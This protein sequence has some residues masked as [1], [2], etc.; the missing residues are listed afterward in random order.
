MER[1]LQ[2]IA[3]LAPG[4]QFDAFMTSIS[5]LLYIL[6]W[7][8]L[9][10]GLLLGLK[11][12]RMRPVHPGSTTDVTL[13][14]LIGAIM[15]ALTG[16]LWVA[17]NPIKIV[18]PYIHLRLFSFFTAVVGILFGRGA[19][20]ICGWVATMVWAPLAGAFVLPH[21]PLFD[22]IFVGLTGWIPAV[23]I[24]GNK[25]TAEVLRDIQ[26]NARLWY[27]K[28]AAACLFAGLFMSF[29][30]AVSLE[31][32]TTLTFWMSFW[33]IGIVSDTAPLVLATAPVVHA[34][35]LAT[36]RA[37]SWMPQF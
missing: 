20:F 7:I 34:L 13:G 22:G 17:Y 3:A 28:T 31:L 32:T 30:V 8:V 15:G 1:F 33:A 2:A 37:Q 9:I 10:A 29:F 6:G 18:P 4:G 27:A 16:L 25:T 35:L 26:E 23:L 36:R 11:Y 21:T 12:Q 19:G 5:P 14:L 24:R